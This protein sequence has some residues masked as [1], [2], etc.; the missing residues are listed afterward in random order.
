VT[1]RREAAY[2]ADLAY[3][4]DVGFAGRDDADVLRL[5]R[6]CGVRRGLVVDLGCGPGAWARRLGD[7][8]YD[9]LGVDISPAMIARAKRRAP[10]ARFAVGSLVDVAIPPCDAVTSLGECVNY[11]FDARAGR[12][13]LRRL[14]RRIHAALRPG[15]V[16]LF[17]VRERER[18]RSGVFEGPDWTIALRVEASGDGRRVVRRIVTFRRVGRLHRRTEEIHRLRLYRRADLASDLRRAG[19]AVRVLPG[20]GRTPLGPG[21]AAVVARKR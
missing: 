10:R 7:A 8:G 17:D 11:L 1:S 13:S 16:F 5:L 18:S 12:A 21:R 2:G 6:R 20:F 19:F 3:V 4:H 15:G 14:F 9:V